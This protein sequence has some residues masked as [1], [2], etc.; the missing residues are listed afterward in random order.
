MT[1]C[2]PG[3]ATPIPP[4]RFY[5]PHT[6][7]PVAML[8]RQQQTPRAHFPLS[9]FQ[10]CAFTTPTPPMV[11]VQRLPLQPSRPSPWQPAT[12]PLHPISWPRSPSPAA[13]GWVPS[14]SLSMRVGRA[15][16]LMLNGAVWQVPECGQHMLHECGAAG[17]DPPGAVH[18]RPAGAGSDRPRRPAARRGVPHAG[19]RAPS[20]GTP[21]RGRPSR[22]QGRHHPQRWQVSGLAA[23]GSLQTPGGLSGWDAL[24]MR[25]EGGLRT[26]TSFCSSAWTCCRPRRPP[27]RGRRRWILCVP[28]LA[29]C[30]DTR[31]SARS[32][33]IRRPTATMTWAFRSTSP[34][35]APM[36]HQR[37][38]ICSATTFRSTRAPHASPATRAC[39]HDTGDTDSEVWGGRCGRVMCRRR[40]SRT[41]VTRVERPRPRRSCTTRSSGCRAYWSCISSGSASIPTHS[42]HTSCTT[43]SASRT[44]STWVRPLRWQGRGV[45]RVLSVRYV[46]GPL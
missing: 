26:H 25:R 8:L 15:P 6:T 24:N 23:R 30:S 19:Q 16:A 7:D 5:G 39:A 46:A 2:A 28:T 27:L 36:R 17:P 43:T 22:A 13:E 3:D 9:R 4:E 29:V 37:C 14:P 10:R 33:G 32:V 1:V 20:Q 42:V 35:S 11:P 12:G 34:S 41:R 45:R 40:R 21:G 31:W 38:R 18:A 44:A